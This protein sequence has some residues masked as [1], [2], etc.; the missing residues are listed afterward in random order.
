MPK[1]GIT[2]RAWRL[3]YWLGYRTAR[4]WWRVRRPHH[5][6]AMVAVWLDGLILGVTQS[7]TNRLTWPG[8][9][10]KHGE[11]PIQA[12]QRELRE[13][14]G[15]S[16]RTDDLTRACRLD[17]ECDHRIDH[18]RIFELRLTAPPILVLDSREITRAAFMH[19][20]EM[21]ASR[22]SPFVRAYLLDRAARL[23]ATDLP[24]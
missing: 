20:N 18:V 23:A 10:I 21:L 4:A 17:V 15:L 2:D 6:G 12:A 1:P 7:Y 19:P 11:A 14:L 3:T 8:G 16:V 9:G 24:P 13:E 5:H 22:T